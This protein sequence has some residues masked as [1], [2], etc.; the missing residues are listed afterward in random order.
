MALT[1]TAIVLTVKQV[2][3]DNFGMRGEQLRMPVYIRIMP[4]SYL[5]R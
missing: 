4:L 2:F 1:G 3:K 5:T